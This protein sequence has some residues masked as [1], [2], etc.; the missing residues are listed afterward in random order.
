MSSPQQTPQDII[1]Y[2]IGDAAFDP[3][4]TKG[5]NKIWYGA[6]PE[7]DAE[8]TSRFGETLKSIEFG[9]LL[10]WGEDASGALALVIV[11]DQFTRNIYRG[12]REAFAQD[13]LA[14]AIAVRAIDRGLERTLSIPGRVFLYHPFEHSESVADQ[15][16][17]VALFA[18][19]VDEVPDEWKEFVSGFTGYAH[20]HRDLIVQFGR[21]PHR[22]EV[23]GRESTDEEKA[24]L[25]NGSRF[26]Q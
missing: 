10:E 20:R 7:I 15:D 4:A 22:N 23:L 18:A 12:K 11:L 17:S 19:L 26:G 3:T 1:D 14:R 8:I 2:W 5:L 21:F 6:D 24:Y 16:R 13:A 25:E 9:R